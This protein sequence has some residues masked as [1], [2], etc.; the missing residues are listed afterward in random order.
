MTASDKAM[1]IAFC[2]ISSGAVGYIEVVALAGAPMEA[3]DGD[4][5]IAT[6]IVASFR[7]LASSLASK[8]PSSQVC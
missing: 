6:S 3:K 8:A 4:I 7:T 2:G 5:G 1:F